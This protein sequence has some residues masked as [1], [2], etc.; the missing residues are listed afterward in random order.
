MVR[1]RHQNADAK[2]R[3]PDAGAASIIYNAT[4]RKNMSH[5]I[6]AAARDVCNATRSLGD[7]SHLILRQRVRGS[8][9]A[10]RAVRN[11]RVF[12]MESRVVADEGFDDQLAT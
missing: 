7:G 2:Y 12:Q 5:G 8:A 3:K 10:V 9:R 1:I 6:I 11:T 4:R